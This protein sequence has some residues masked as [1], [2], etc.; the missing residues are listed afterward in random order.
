[1]AHSLSPLMMT[2]AFCQMEIRGH[3]RAIRVPRAIDIVRSMR[4]MNIEGASI[5]IPHK[6]AV[7]EFLDEI[8]E[9][10]R[11]IGAV[12]TVTSRFGMLKGDNT[13]WIGAERALS[14]VMRIAG[15]RF[16]VLGAGGAARAVVYCIIINGGT[17]VLLNRTEERGEKL[18]R[19]MECEFVPLRE[20]GTVEAECLINTTPVGMWPDIDASPVKRS[21]LSRYTGVMDTIYN[22]LQT[23]LMADAAMAGCVT[24]SGLPMF[25]HQGAEQI[26]LWTGKEPPV[27]SMMRIVREHLTHERN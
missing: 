1:M 14:K 4:S 17:A 24:I 25:V 9:S 12:N 27:D 15:K 8:S 5:T 26:R 19:E 21:V 3:Y 20:I 10:A 6:V 13:D 16:A 2:G 18:A 11:R 22:P 7:V 23:T